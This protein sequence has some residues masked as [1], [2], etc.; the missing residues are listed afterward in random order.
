MERN[1]DSYH[2][3][4]MGV[5]DQSRSLENPETNIVLRFPL[6]PE[7]N[8]TLRRRTRRS[9]PLFLSLIP[10][11]SFVVQHFSASG[12]K[13]RGLISEN[14]N[15]KVI[16]YLPSHLL[17]ARASLKNPVAIPFALQPLLS[18]LSQVANVR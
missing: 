9:P 15:N 11:P 17:Y 2:Q 5:G 6:S 4:S 7:P 3:G 13:E 14:K 8:L 16:Y 12:F 18:P 10:H 1:G